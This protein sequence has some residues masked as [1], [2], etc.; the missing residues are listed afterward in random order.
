MTKKC[1]DA[2]KPLFQR[3]VKE[4]KTQRPVPTDNRELS[5]QKGL[6][7]LSENSK[8]L[9]VGIAKNLRNRLRSHSLGK[10]SL[11]K[12]MALEAMKK[13]GVRLRSPK[14]R[15]DCK[16]YQRES[17]EALKRIKSMLVRSIPWK[18]DDEDLVLL[19]MYTAHALRTHYNKK[20]VLLA[21]A[22]PPLMRKIS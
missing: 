20:L 17:K 7:V 1:A 3:C 21:E 11:K 6:Y 2:L 12:K 16:D 15:R 9:Y 4:L 13:K 5:K 18:G 19:E 22:E 10:S 8:Y 14:P